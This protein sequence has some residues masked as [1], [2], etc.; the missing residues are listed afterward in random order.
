MKK[1]LS[2]LLI[3]VFAL[4]L[5]GC[6]QIEDD[7][8][9]VDCAE[10]PNHV[11]C[12][13]EGGGAIE[14][15]PGIINVLDALPDEPITIT[16]WHVYGESKGA[17]LNEFIDEFEADYPNV[18]VEAISQGDY[19]TIRSNTLNAITAGNTPTMVV[20]YP[21]HVAGYLKGNAVIPLDDFIYDENYGVNLD[22][23]IESYLA[24]NKQYAGGYMYSFPY[25]KSTE[26][27]VYNKD[28]FAAAGITVPQDEIITWDMLDTWA[29]TLVNENY[30]PGSNVADECQYL[31]NFDS[32]SNFF[33]NSVRMWDGGY[34]NSEGEILVDNAN[35][36]DMLEYV[37]TRFEDNTFSLPLA[38]NES[39]GSNNFIAGDV[40]MS[41][42]ST[43]GINYNI[44]PSGEFDVGVL[45][46]PQY[47]L[48]N[49]S[50]VQQGPNIAIMSNTTDAERLASWLLIKYLTK[51]ENT[52]AWAMETGYLPVRHSGVQS[53]DYQAFLEIDDPT[54]SL[55]YSSL[56]AQA[57]YAQYEYF[58]YDPA[59]AGAVTSSDAR[60]QAGVAMEALFGGYSAQEVIDDMVR[61]LGA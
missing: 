37:K 3:T 48:D 49:K 35:T 20:G 54:D 4:G 10:Y 43:A 7:P 57:A 41:V 58:E 42:G 13:D 34:T 1:V 61:Q 28:K 60:F 8:Y 50:A 26:M 11:S 44:P 2:L 9:Q 40:C 32:A 55:Y 15:A 14:G 16:F 27:M 24:E 23:F 12:L 33:I 30:V 59:F 29:D 52:A 6:V 19:D 47:D 53:A 18:T 56:A 46:I 36:I 22:D 38:W 39:Y 17:L 31:L 5:T 21:D 45:P 51:A 25:S